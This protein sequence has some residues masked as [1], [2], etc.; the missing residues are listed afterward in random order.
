MSEII[1]YGY[2]CTPSKILKPKWDRI[3][4]DIIGIEAEFDNIRFDPCS[5]CPDDCNYCDEN[6]EI[7]YNEEII[8]KINDL[9]E[10]NFIINP[11]NEIHAKEY[12]NVVIERDSSVDLELIFQA[13]KR[14]NIM[15][16]ITKL[17]KELEP[18]SNNS[19]GTS[20]HIHR[21]KNWIMKEYDTSLY[22]IQDTTEFLLPI[23]Y[24]ISGRTP[25]SY[26]NWCHSIFQDYK[27]NVPETLWNIGEKIDKID[28]Y[29]YYR[30]NKYLACNI[31]HDESIEFRIFS[32]HHNL[33][34]EISK[35]YID[36]TNLI[37]EMSQYMNRK[38][39]CNEYETLIDWVQEWKDSN[40]RRKSLLNKYGFDNLLLSKKD[41][42]IKD[43]NKKYDNIYNKMLYY[44]NRNKLK[45]YHIGMLVDDLRNISHKLNFDIDVD[46]IC[47]K[48]D[49]NF[50]IN[51]NDIFE[52]LNS[53][54]Y[55]ELNNL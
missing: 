50:S 54:Y 39:F 6:T 31:K 30:K 2:G 33:N 40:K 17:S 32:N 43:L 18:V 38:S 22:R 5:G 24:L 45:N 3:E 15:R 20:F 9:I 44:S 55:E 47:N 51:F 34:Y 7:E 49:N 48:T 14:Q 25:S 13:D 36:S 46:I 8:D 10:R 23:L 4:K 35:L 26:E 16:N 52:Y 12:G 27:Y 11:D 29:L 37:L 1:K 42:L 53:S 19:S 21:N 41:C 28:E